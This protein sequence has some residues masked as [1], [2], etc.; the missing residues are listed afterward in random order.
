MKKGKEVVET[1]FILTEKLEEVINNYCLGM[2]S[3][4]NA[5][6]T[7]LGLNE[8]EEILNTYSQYL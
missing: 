3:I 1:Y 5:S 7:G 4:E 8:V 2:S 6:I